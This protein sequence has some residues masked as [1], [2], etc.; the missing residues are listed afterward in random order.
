VLRLSIFLVVVLSILGGV[1]FYLWARLVRD[2]QLPLPARTWAT[3]ALLGLAVSVLVTFLLLRRLSP[4]WGRVLAWPAFTWLGV[5]FFAFTLVLVGDLVRL[6]LFVQSKVSATP[7]DPG[8]RLMLARFLGGG[9]AIGAGVAGSFALRRALARVEV[10]DV[11][12]RLPR[13]AA[14]R[15]GTTI[16]QLTDLHV[17]PTIGRAFIEDIVRRTNDL[18]PDLVAITGDLVDG[19]VERLRHAVEPLRDL[20]ATHGVF[21]VTGNHEYF[22]GPG[23]WRAELRRLGIRV[24]ENERVSIG[25]GPDAFDVA[26]VE[27][28]SAARIGGD[29]RPDLVGALAGRDPSRPLILLAHQPRAIFEAARQQVDLQ[30]SGHTHGGQLWPFTYLV[31]LQQPYVAGLHQHGNT[32]IY[33]SPGTGY[34]GPPMRLGTRAEITRLTLRSA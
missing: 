5:M 7:L 29:S 1:H 23:P 27:D 2:T 3:A 19:S 33:V 20:K 21:F 32:Q 30:L 26:G 12:V 13:L 15:D 8:R 18:R 25:E 34:W 28:H 9:A 17:G 31:K 16:V 11:T 4:E 14:S 22:S 10:V 6:L 24:L